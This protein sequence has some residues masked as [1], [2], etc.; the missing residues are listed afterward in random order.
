MESLTPFQ[1]KMLIGS[2]LSASFLFLFNQFLLI[3]A[4]PQIMADFGINATQVQW[5][6]N[7]FLLTTT[8]LIP[9]MGYFMGRFSTRVLTLVA[10]GFFI[11]GTGLA[12]IAPSFSLLIVAR[13]VQAI[14]A[15]MMLPL[16]QTVL[17]LVYPIEK[18]GYAMGLMTM[19][20]NVA[21]AIGPSIAGYI[22]D[23]YNW[24]FLF[25]LVLPLTI[26]LFILNAKYMRNI[27][28]QATS[29]LDIPSL[30]LSAVGF[31]GII[32]AISN[33]SVYGFNNSFVLIP[34]LVGVLAL[35]L[36]IWK[37]LR[38]DAPM[39]NLHLFKR[40]WFVH[41]TILTFVISILL[42][43]TET[44]LPLFIQ[45][46]QNRSAFISGMVL[47][48]GTLLLSLTAFLSGKWFDRFGGKI[49]G[50]IGYSTLLITFVWFSLMGAETS[51]ASMIICF[52]LFMGAV[53]ITMTPATAIAMNALKQEDLAHGTAILNTLKQFGAALGVTVLTTIVSLNAAKPDHSYVEGTLIGLRWA[54]LTMSILS[55]VALLLVIFAQNRSKSSN[56]LM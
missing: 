28:D 40:K 17:L 30:V 46:G 52:S 16:V 31:A 3:T 43:S 34:A 36:F 21:P 56:T 24:R 4:F 14:G 22:V 50:L 27:T 6:T 10:I 45:D 25:W 29:R 15:G 41:G 51:V 44:L 7:S 32:L 26:V 38:M 53:G 55:L 11:V 39:L 35:A 49:L 42:L 13:V 8:I 18:R 9:T 23:L 48:P 2:I 19:V 33:S 1:R 20:V 12:I 5:L 37:Q 47:L 54:F